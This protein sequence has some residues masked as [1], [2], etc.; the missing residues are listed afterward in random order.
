MGRCR[1]CRAEIHDGDCNCTEWC[2][3]CSQPGGYHDED[4][5]QRGSEVVGFGFT[6]WA[7]GAA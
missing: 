6:A 1:I 3:E 2:D 7:D 4:C 5:P